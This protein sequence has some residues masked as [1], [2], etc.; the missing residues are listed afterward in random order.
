MERGFYVLKQTVKNPKPDRRC[1][2]MHSVTEWESGLRVRVEPGTDT[3]RGTINFGDNT[4]VYFGGDD[5]D[6]D[7]G[8]LL[9]PHLEKAE[10]AIGQLFRDP[11]VQAQM[12][13]VLALAVEQ[14]LIN[15]DQVKTLVDEI[16]KMEEEPYFAFK[17]KH[18][19][20]G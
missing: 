10:F 12:S 1:K 8:N 7:V 19:I 11:F 18:W 13:D 5:P 16:D 4:Q 6:L 14:G 15:A 2:A 17:K 9:V 20:K 3:R